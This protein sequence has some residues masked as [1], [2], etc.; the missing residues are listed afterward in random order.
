MP[1]DSGH[2]L[3]TA[4]EEVPVFLPNHGDEGKDAFRSEETDQH[5]N[6]SIHP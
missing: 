2:V 4:D 3:K 6:Q 1:E 5:L